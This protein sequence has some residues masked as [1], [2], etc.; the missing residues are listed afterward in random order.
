MYSVSYRR[1]S[2]DY[3]QVELPFYPLLYDLQVEHPQK[4]AS[5]TEAQG[6]RGIF[7]IHKGGIIELQS[8]NGIL[9]FLVVVGI[10]WIY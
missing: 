6:C 9:K 8:L 7:F 4:A 1:G 3:G 2:E 10:H 5:E